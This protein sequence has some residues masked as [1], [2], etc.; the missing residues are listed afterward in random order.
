MRLGCVLR[1]HAAVLFGIVF[2]SASAVGAD[3]T[4]QIAP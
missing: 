4:A 3:K 1:L 2:G